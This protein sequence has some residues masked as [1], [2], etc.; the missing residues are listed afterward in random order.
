[1]EWWEPSYWDLRQRWCIPCVPD[2]WCMRVR[3]LFHMAYTMVFFRL[4]MSWHLGQQKSLLKFSAKHASTLEP[5]HKIL[6]NSL[7]M[8]SNLS[9]APTLVARCPID[10]I[11]EK[12]RQA[13]WIIS[14]SNSSIARHPRT[15]S[16]K[17][18]SQGFC[19]LRNPNISPDAPMD[20]FQTERGSR[21][22]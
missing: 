13:S 11:T 6:H 20:E 2:L 10:V 7:H 4:C 21:F 16:P 5:V 18:C 3:L 15:I 1:M 12:H 9:W 22:I 17:F 8:Q 19:F 14:W